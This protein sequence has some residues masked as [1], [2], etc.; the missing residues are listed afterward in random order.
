MSEIK[1]FKTESKRLLDL[2]INSI[3]T[4]KE[5]FLRELI[6]NASDAIDK[7]HYLSLNDEK[8]TK[9]DH[10]KISL[11]YDKDQRTIT[12]EDNGI[13]MT[14]DELNDHLG[15]IAKSGSLEFMK[16]LKE[17]EN[18]ENKDVDIIGQF[19]VGFYSAFMVA[20]KVEVNTK[21]PYSEKGY[22]F[23]STG[24]D[25][26]EV[27]ETTKEDHGTSIT[28]YLRANDEEKEENY[29]EFLSDWKIKELVKKYS[30]YVRYPIE[31][32]V[33]TQ[34]KDNDK[35]DKYH[36]ETRL[37]VL[38]SMI[39]LWKKN[40]SEVTKEEL[41]S[42]YKQK[43]GAYEDPLASLFVNVEGLISYNA[44][45]YI[46]GKAPYNLY[47]DKFERGLQLYTKG[48][49]I[50]DK[51]KE[52]IPDY[53]RFV[54]GL[55]DTSDVSLNISREMLQQNRQLVKIGNSVEKKI[56]AE[57]DR[58][59]KEDFEN[60]K[61]FFKEFGIN[62]KYGIYESYGSKNDS[63]KDL[64]I[65]SH[66]NDDEMITLEKYVSEMKEGQEF[67]YY[68][69]NKSIDAVKAMPQL[70][71]LKKKGYDVLVFNDDID[72]FAINFL[73]EYN[74]KKFKS[75][76]QGDLDLLN[77]D[78][79]KEMNQLK[80][81]KKPLID[82]IKSALNDKVKD[83]IISERLVDSPVCLVSGEDMSFEMEKVLSQMPN[84]NGFKASKILEINPHHQLFK[85][86]EKVY[87]TSPESLKDYSSLLLDQAMLMEG[88]MIENPIDFSNKM[89]SLMI[90]S[91]SLDEV[92]SSNEDEIKD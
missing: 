31:M 14:Y 49:F 90:K 88:M 38:N 68:A 59:K 56:L 6:S 83:V 77:E 42:F 89:C 63:L 79:K 37:E 44:L 2:M 45:L 58:M 54:T 76:N 46:P 62:L 48:V 86:L 84:Q 80:D 85:A 35:E 60:Y 36:D 9:E 39:P 5:I 18:E 92:S 50:Q 13:G 74:S 19:G 47:S 41:N 72:E 20:S 8:L 91:A 17:S 43:F 69:S 75:I 70:D 3:Y 61:K 73:A 16:K 1:E 15:T 32:F 64:L 57:L 52:L 12:I 34:V 65:Y 33:T 10:Y 21:S 11:S 29:D 26:Y 87:E 67:I 30:D 25:T 22:K 51:C 40:K 24:T 4:N 81:E 53:L 82:A 66:I 27:E 23:T 71:A 7:Y 55:V 28:L 78:E